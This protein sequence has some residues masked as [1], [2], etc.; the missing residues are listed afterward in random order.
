MSICYIS[1]VEPRICLK[2]TNNHP[3]HTYLS[4]PDAI[5]DFLKEYMEDL[6]TECILVFN[7]DI[8]NTTITVFGHVNLISLISMQ[9]SSLHKTDYSVKKRNAPDVFEVHLF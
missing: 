9:R 8:R 1:E 2:E 4:N 5:L 7:L 3:Y 6:T